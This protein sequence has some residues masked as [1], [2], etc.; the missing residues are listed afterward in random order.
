MPRTLLMAAVLLLAGTGCSLLP[1]HEAADNVENAKALRIGQTKEEV[2]AIMGEP[3]SDEQYCT[4]NCW[5][6]YV[7]PVWC[8]GLTTED[9]CIPLVFEN[10]R[11]VGFGRRFY[12]EYRLRARNN[13]SEVLPVE[14]A[15]AKQ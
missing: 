7:E 4:P 10:G 12:T 1:W 3:L 2:L 14:T 13:A 5:F 15:P 8:D 6:Y 11:L 9:E